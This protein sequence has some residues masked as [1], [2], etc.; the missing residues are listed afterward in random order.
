MIIFLHTLSSVLSSTCRYKHT[1]THTRIHTHTHTDTHTHTHIL[2]PNIPA[3]SFSHRSTCMFLLSDGNNISLIMGITREAKK[4]NYPQPWPT[5]ITFNINV[6]L[7]CLLT[8]I[9]NQHSSAKLAPG[10]R[11]MCNIPYRD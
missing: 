10:V 7:Q 4:T 11:N 2:S 5:S 1:H 9:I 8:A 3:L 6:L